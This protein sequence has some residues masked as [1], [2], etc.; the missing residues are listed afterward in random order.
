MQELI[1]KLSMDPLL[2]K[3]VLKYVIYTEGGPGP[4]EIVEH[5][6]NNDGTPKM[7]I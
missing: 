1:D 2:Q 7:L 3:D 6:L 4:C 5:L